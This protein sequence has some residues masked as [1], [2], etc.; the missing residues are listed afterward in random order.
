MS[1]RIGSYHRKVKKEECVKEG[2]RA[3]YTVKWVKKIQEGED[4][5][6]VT[7][8]TRDSL[9]TFEGAVSSG[10]WEWN[11]ECKELGSKWM[12]VKPRQ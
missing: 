5:D 1:K 7:L 6:A 3:P 9:V 2:D 8:A 12:L 4:Q 11:P 10:L